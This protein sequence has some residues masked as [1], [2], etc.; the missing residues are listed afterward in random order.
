MSRRTTQ[1]AQTTAES[2]IASEAQRLQ[3]ENPS[4]TRAKAMTEAWRQNPKLKAEHRSAIRSMGKSGA[5]P[6]KA[7]ELKRRIRDARGDNEFLARRASEPLRRSL[8]A[9]E[10]R[11]RSAER[12]AFVASE[13]TR[14]EAVAPGIIRKF[15]ESRR[16]GEALR[17]EY[18]RIVAAEKAEERRAEL[19]AGRILRRFA[20]GG[21]EAGMAEL[22]GVIAAEMMDLC[23]SSC[24]R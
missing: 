12:R 7:A 14:A 4:W 19:A 23:A 6:F 22:V 13:E 3:R 1:T 11:R 5:Q 18:E 9:A 17:P 2:K 21:R 15:G 20:T 10:A 24:S 16:A 8:S